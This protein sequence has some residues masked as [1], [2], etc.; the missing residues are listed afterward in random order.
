MF[1]LNEIALAS[2]ATAKI[3]A[4]KRV[5][6]NAHIEACNAPSNVSNQPLSREETFKGAQYRLQ[7]LRAL[8]SGEYELFIAIENGI[9]KIGDEYYDTPVVM[10][11][12]TD[13][14][15]PVLSI[16]GE[17]VCIPLHYAAMACESEG[18]KTIGTLLMEKNVHLD[19]Q[20][21]HIYLTNYKKSREDI[22]A[23]VLRKAFM[24]YQHI[25]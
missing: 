3:N 7:N 19:H 4:C 5:F 2:A 21:P 1:N 25:V 12:G 20:D 13:P 11:Q 14:F 8:S 23:E 15:S 10:I 24:A 16:T 22:L 17:S 9:W 6:K 18:V